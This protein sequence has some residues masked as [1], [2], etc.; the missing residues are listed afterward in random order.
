MANSGKE[1]ISKTFNIKNI[2][3]LPQYK[4]IMNLNEGPRKEITI[5]PGIKQGCSLSP[6]LFN[7]YLHDL[8]REWKDRTDQGT[9][10]RQGYI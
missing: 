4:I 5:N 9:K 8:L 7:I 3:P 1:K 2:K 6:S 10:I